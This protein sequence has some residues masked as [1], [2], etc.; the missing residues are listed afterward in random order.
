REAARF[1]FGL[2][3]GV[4]E[5][6]L[7]GKPPFCLI[8]GGETTVTVKGKGKGGRNQEMA[9][10]FIEELRREGLENRGLFFL[11][12][13]TDGND[14]PTDAAGAFASWEI[15]CRSRRAGLSSSRYLE[16]NDSYHFFEQSGGLLKT[17]A[18]RTNVCDIQIFIVT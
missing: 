13:S 15:L 14:G 3:R 1:Y 2:A 6:G 10:A 11:A 5:H 12:A 18:T 8:A 17:G 16:E 7:L 9:L 4:Q